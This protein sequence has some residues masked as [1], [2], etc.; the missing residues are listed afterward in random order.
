MSKLSEEEIIINANLII[1]E[2]YDKSEDDLEGILQGLL[3]LYK[4]EKDRCIELATTIDALKTDYEEEKE[5]NKELQTYMK[6][7]L[8]PKSTINLVYI[9]KDKIKEKMKKYMNLISARESIRR[10]GKEYIEKMEILK[11]E[12]LKEEHK[13]KIGIKVLQELLEEGDK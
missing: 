12:H 4:Q 6:E 7:Y 3:D 5:K 8:I 1:N 13:A 9:S 2:G 10:S 11:P